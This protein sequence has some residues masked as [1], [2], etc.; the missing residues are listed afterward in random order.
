MPHFKDGK[1][2]KDGDYVKAI[3]HNG[4][5]VIGRLRDIMPGSDTCNGYVDT[6]KL[7]P[8]AEA[9]CLNIKD[10]ELLHRD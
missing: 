7:R 6:I 2:A 3:D 1:E 5:I 10:M 9:Y 4:D 8:V